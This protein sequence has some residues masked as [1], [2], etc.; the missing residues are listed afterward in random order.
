MKEKGGSC[1]M[2]QQ[3][4]AHTALA[5]DQSAVLTTLVGQLTTA[6][7]PISLGP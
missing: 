6:Y 3:L 2:A 4:G 5:E 7:N 1:G